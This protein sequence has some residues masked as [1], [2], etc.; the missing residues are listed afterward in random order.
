M[1][2]SQIYNLILKSFTDN[3]RRVNILFYLIGAGFIWYL[4]N[5]KVLATVILM[6]LSIFVFSSLLLSLFIWI[7]AGF[8]GIDKDC[9]K[10]LLLTI[11]IL[12]IV[13]FTLDLQ[14]LGYILV[15]SLIGMVLG[16]YL[17]K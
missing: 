5:L 15:L 6:M 3:K 11:V 17:S 9:I 2:I 4:Y 10:S 12:P 16:I 7:R 13:F 1:R 8:K 14:L